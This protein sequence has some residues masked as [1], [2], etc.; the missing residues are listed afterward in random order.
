MGFLLLLIFIVVP[1][2]EIGLFIEIGGRIGLWPTLALVV[3][4]AV[5]GT[6]L[7]RQQGL[8]TLRQA[9][10][11]IE[12]GSMP[13][14]E[15]FDGACLLFAGALLLTPGFLTDAAGALLLIPALRGL[16]RRTLAHRLLAAGQS[17][18]G[19]GSGNPFPG[20]RLEV[21]G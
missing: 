18:L 17:N 21:H 2:V 13:L 7:L 14:K 5:L 12:R 6:T 4:T 8:S 10:V 15:L 19:T 3:L 20:A 1:I 11:S 16:L 9:Q